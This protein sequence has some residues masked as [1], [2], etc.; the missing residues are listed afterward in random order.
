MRARIFLLC[1][2]F[3]SVQAIYAQ[4]ES[5]SLEKLLDSLFSVSTEAEQEK[6]INTITALNPNVE[7]AESLL[8][9]GRKYPKDVPVGW[10]IYENLCIDGIN[11]PYHIYI[12]EDYNPNKKYMVFFYLHGL[13]SRDELIPKDEFIEKR[14][15]WVDE[16]KKEEFIYVLPMGRAGATWWNEIGA[17]HILKILE[18]VKRRYNIDENRVFLSGFSDGGSGAYYMAL[19]YSTP[20]AGFISLNGHIGVAQAG[21]NPIY[22]PNLYNRPLYIVNTGKDYLY[23]ID[24]VTPYIEKICQIAGEVTFKT[25]QEFGHLPPFGYRDKEKPL[26]LEFMRN[27]EREPFSSRLKWET[28]SPDLGRID[29][30]KIEKIEDISNNVEFDD[31]NPITTYKR[32]TIGVDID[33]GFKGKGVRIKK[34]REN[35]LAERLNLK[36]GDVIIGLDDKETD[37]PSTLREIISEKRP[38][39]QISLIIIRN[40]KR[41]T[42]EGKFEKPEPEPAFSREKLSGRIEAEVTGNRI[43]VKVKNIGAYTVFISRDQF[44]IDKDIE[45]YTNGELS[46]KGKIKPDIEFM[47]RQATK[48]MDRSMIFIGKIEIAVKKK[49]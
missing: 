8:K 31:L 17:Q 33:Y 39:D 46:F 49:I 19:N 38:G 40:N 43:D 44:D 18:N 15:F 29:W 41:L 28:S 14:S 1:I 16:A 25:Y 13:V 45:I 48:D 5:E 2:L 34:I 7:K 26:I 30:L 20:F 23:P 24:E 47:L 11:R 10:N 4:R 36:S 9:A 6:V 32:V 22:L 3:L 27:T 42:F 21:G 35:T 37:K 12:P